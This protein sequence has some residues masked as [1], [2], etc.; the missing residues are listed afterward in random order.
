VLLCEMVQLYLPNMLS[1]TD[2]LPHA[3]LTWMPDGKNN[4]SAGGGSS[5]PDPAP[6]R[7]QDRVAAQHHSRALII[8][9][10]QDISICHQDRSIWPPG[11]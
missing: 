9:M 10:A 4:R 2:M 7:I 6:S 8:L 5:C 11:L 1:V 3:A